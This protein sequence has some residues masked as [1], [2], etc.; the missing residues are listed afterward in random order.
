VKS[1][2]ISELS[3]KL[4]EL[5]EQGGKAQKAVQDLTLALEKHKKENEQLSSKLEAGNKAVEDL[6]NQLAEA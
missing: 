1:G 6:E 4:A 2:E 3:E 5:S